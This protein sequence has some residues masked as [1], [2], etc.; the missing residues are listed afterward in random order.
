[1]KP[2]ELID[3]PGNG[4]HGVNGCIESARASKRRVTPKAGRLSHRQ[5]FPLTTK[6]DR[7]D[8]R[9]ARATVDAVQAEVQARRQSGEL[10]SWD[11]CCLDSLF[12][13]ALGL[14]RAYRYLGVKGWLDESA[15]GFWPVVSGVLTLQRLFKENLADLGLDKLPQPENFFDAFFRQQRAALANP[16][17]PV[18]ASGP[19]SGSNGQDYPQEPGDGKALQQTANGDVPRS[20]ATSERET[21]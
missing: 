15:G 9:I 7:T 20:D 11:W 17:A 5:R 4:K 19:I 8:V 18:S 1:M 10:S 21:P 14:S 16:V 2:S 3:F 12:S 13:C 6:Q